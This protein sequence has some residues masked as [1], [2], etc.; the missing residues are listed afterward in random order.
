MDI[1]MVTESS[2]T[3]GLVMVV[4][5]GVFLVGFVA[6]IA[7]GEPAVIALGAMAALVLGIFGTIYVDVSQS[8]RQAT[9]IAQII[10][11]EKNIDLDITDLEQLVDSSYDGEI[12]PV[13]AVVD[14]SPAELGANVVNNK[15]FVFE[16]NGSKY[17][18]FDGK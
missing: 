8:G 1:S 7:A 11:A 4:C 17:E 18:P 3:I 16:K 14:G 15:V 6:A 9:E 10:S 2:I 13:G 12:V 5:L